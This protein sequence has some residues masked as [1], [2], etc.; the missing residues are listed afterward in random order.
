MPKGAEGKT[1]SLL[2]RTVDLFELTNVPLI[3][4]TERVELCLR[5]RIEAQKGKQ[6]Q[7]G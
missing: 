3:D 7:D 1:R 5:E 2:H 4:L 6:Q